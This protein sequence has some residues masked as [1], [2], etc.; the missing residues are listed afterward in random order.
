MLMNE[1]MCKALLES[2]LDSLKFSFQGVD[3]VSYQEMRGGNFD[4]LISNIMRL[5]KL[6]GEKMSPFI[7]VSTTTTYE[8]EDQR[9]TFRSLLINY[10]DLVTL[11]KTKLEHID[12]EKSTLPPSRKETLKNL[13]KK[14]SFNEVRFRVCPEVFAK[15]SIGWNGDVSACDLDY[16]AKMV[17]GN[18]SEDSLLNIFNSVTA[19]HYRALLREKA[20]D[21]IPLCKR[22][23]DIVGLQQN[24]SKS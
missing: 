10:C 11:G 6:R 21:D 7:H 13:Q 22:C 16:D 1:N 12:I 17:I 5:H 15:M 18:I 4:F 2:G 23:F 24:I 20:F 14:Q 9:E 19:L 8:T 3:T